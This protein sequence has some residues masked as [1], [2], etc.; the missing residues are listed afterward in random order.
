MHVVSLLKYRLLLSAKQTGETIFLSP[1]LA[2]VVKDVRNRCQREKRILLWD[3]PR[4]EDNFSTLCLLSIFV[5]VIL[6]L[7]KNMQSHLYLDRCLV[8]MQ[9]LKKI[10]KLLY[11]LNSPKK[12]IGSCAYCNLHMSYFVFTTFGKLSK[13]RFSLIKIKSSMNKYLTIT[14][15]M[16][17]VYICQSHHET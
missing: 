10:L 17:L 1:F 13:L 6:F 4:R 7:A 3:L 8:F 16:D 14:I 2:K 9:I 5:S 12:L 11:C 15:L